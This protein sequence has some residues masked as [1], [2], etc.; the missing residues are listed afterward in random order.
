[1]SMHKGKH[2]KVAL[3]GKGL[4]CGAERTQYPDGQVAQGW[5]EDELIVRDAC[6]APSVGHIQQPVLA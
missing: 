3:A 2:C 6:A 1:M 4:V 5:R